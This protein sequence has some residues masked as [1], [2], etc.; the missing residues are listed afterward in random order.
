[1]DE[2]VLEAYGWHIDSKAGKAL[3]LKHDFYEVEYL[4]ENDRV[5]YTIPEDIR[6]KILERLLILNHKMY[7]KE[8]EDGLLDKIKPKEQTKT[9][10]KKKEKPEEPSLFDY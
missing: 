3:D 2:A 10:D 6:K 4:P 8:V 7:K 5:R 9:K 1:M